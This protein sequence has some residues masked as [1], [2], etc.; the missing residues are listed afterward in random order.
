[1]RI[2][3]S[4]VAVGGTGRIGAVHILAVVPIIAG[5]ARA[6]TRSEIAGAP[7]VAETAVD[8]RTGGPEVGVIAD[9]AAVVGVAVTPATAGRCSAAVGCPATIDADDGGGSGSGACSAVAAHQF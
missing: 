4:V 2:A 7:I 8:A 9:T 3:P 5:G 6:D 1:M